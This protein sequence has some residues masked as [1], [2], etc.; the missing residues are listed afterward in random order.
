MKKHSSIKEDLNKRRRELPKNITIRNVP[1]ETFSLMEVVADGRCFFGSFW[2]LSLTPQKIRMYMTDPEGYE[3]MDNF[4]DNALSNFIKNDI[5]VNASK[6]QKMTMMRVHYTAYPEENPGVAKSLDDIL[7]Y[8]EQGDSYVLDT[9]CEHETNPN[10]EGFTEEIEKSYEKLTQKGVVQEF[11]KYLLSYYQNNDAS[12]YTDAD[13]FL[14]GN[15]MSDLFNVNVNIVKTRHDNPLVFYIDATFTGNNDP[16]GKEEIYIYFRHSHFQ[17][18]IPNSILHG[19]NR[20]PI[21]KKPAAVSASTSKPQIEKNPMEQL[22]ESFPTLDED[23]ITQVYDVNNK[24]YTNAYHQL[25]VM[26]EPGATPYAHKVDAKKSLDTG[27]SH[28]N[29]DARSFDNNVSS[30]YFNLDESPGI[31]L[32]NET[33]RMEV[34]NCLTEK[35]SLNE[36]FTFPKRLKIKYVVST[37]SNK[38]PT[39]LPSTGTWGSFRGKTSTT[40]RIQPWGEDKPDSVY[41]KMNEKFTNPDIQTVEIFNGDGNIQT[42]ETYKNATENWYFLVTLGAEPVFKGGRTRKR[43]H[44]RGPMRSHKKRKT[45][46]RCYRTKRQRRLSQTKHRKHKSK[47][48]I[49]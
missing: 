20:T 49:F 40:D 1:D 22:I 30:E 11:D 46:T 6:C 23:T 31:Q 12:T 4:V 3:A 10:A 5:F 39:D 21:A 35:K 37:S 14:L 27:Q 47:K 9:L 2:L 41:S 28:G 32:N 8:D 36:Y 44:K 38:V 25:A 43:Q 15:F 48:I 26:E 24:N 19:D 16:G 34:A 13:P 17:P 29:R 33:L 45:N 7:N 18:M 42:P